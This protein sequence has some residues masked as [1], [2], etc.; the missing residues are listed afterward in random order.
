MT[1]KPKRK[2]SSEIIE[3]LTDAGFGRYS[4]KT[5]N[6]LVE[7]VARKMGWKYCRENN[8]WGGSFDCWFLPD[9]T[10]KFVLPDWPHSVDALLAKGGPVETKIYQILRKLDK[11]TPEYICPEILRAVYEA[12]KKEEK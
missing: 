6:Q 5:L 4:D 7:D 8:P 9:G 3:E 12:M 1:S 10:T 2:K 11:L